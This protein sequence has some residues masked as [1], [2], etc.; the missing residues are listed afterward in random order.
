MVRPQLAGAV[1][2]L[3]KIANLRCSFTGSLS[4]VKQNAARA[5]LKELAA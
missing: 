1:L 3:L 5:R 4:Q 2:G